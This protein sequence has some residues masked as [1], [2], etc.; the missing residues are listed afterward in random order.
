MNGSLSPGPPPG[1]RR[2]PPCLVQPRARDVSPPSSELPGAALA[3]AWAMLPTP[4][5]P[6]VWSWAGGT[7]GSAVQGVSGLGYVGSGRT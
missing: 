7:R 3:L 5:L 4:I 1:S 6:G 2:C